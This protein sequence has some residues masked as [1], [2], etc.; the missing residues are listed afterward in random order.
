M[1]KIESKT[2]K[3]ETRNW[4]GFLRRKRMSI[5]ELFLSAANKPDAESPMKTRQTTRAT[6]LTKKLFRIAASLKRTACLGK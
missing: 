6:A 5:L 2:G 1:L 3:I 4:M